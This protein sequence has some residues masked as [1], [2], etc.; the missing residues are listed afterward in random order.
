MWDV[1]FLL[2][3]ICL[4]IRQKKG[5]LECSLL[6]DFSIRF[7]MDNTFLGLQNNNRWHVM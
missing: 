3:T 6:L 2:F 5:I 7:H 4:E 1:L